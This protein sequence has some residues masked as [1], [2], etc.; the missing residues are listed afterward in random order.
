MTDP[1]VTA[2]SEVK[3]DLAKVAAFW[4]DYRLYFVAA[5]CL[6]LGAIAGYKFHP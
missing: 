1:L 4:S 6:I 2:A 5:A 3:A